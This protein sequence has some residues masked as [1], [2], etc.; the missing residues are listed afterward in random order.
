MVLAK[1]VGNVVS[2]NKEPRIEGIKFLLLEKVDPV[3]MKG[4]GDYVVAMDSVG[5]GEG[6]IV[7]YVSGSSSRMTAV[8]NGRPSDAAVTAIVDLVDLD[9]KTVYRKDGGLIR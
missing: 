6:E 5:A 4:K 1:V 7:F 8:T 2:T 3:T 9:G